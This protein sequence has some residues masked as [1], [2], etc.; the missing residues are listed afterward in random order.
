MIASSPLQFFMGQLYP[1]LPVLPLVC[2]FSQHPAALDWVEAR[3]R[4]RWGRIM[5]GSARFE[6]AETNYYEA[7]M[8]SGIRKCFWV[9]EQLANPGELAEWKLLSNQWEDDLA[10]DPAFAGLQPSVARPVNIDPGYITTAK[11]VLASTKDHAHRIYLERGIFAEITLMYRHRAWEAHEWT[12]PDYRRADYQEFFS[13]AR[14]YL[15]SQLARYP[16][17]RRG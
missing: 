16:D 1:P 13:A 10:R 8:G 6:F 14:T 9:F 2:A 11:L 3:A 17:P 15:K 12:F 5:L 4:E 7:T